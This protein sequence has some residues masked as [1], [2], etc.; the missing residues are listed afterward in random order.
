[1]MLPCL[2]ILVAIAPQ[3][4]VELELVVPRYDRWSIVSPDQRQVLVLE[5]GNAW[6]MDSDS[7][8]PC[9]GVRLGPY[10][11][12]GDH[13]TGGR[14]SRDGERVLLWSFRGAAALLDVESGEEL[15]RDAP[16]DRSS[17]WDGHASEDAR[18]LGQVGAQGVVVH[19]MVTGVPLYE[20][21]IA[22]PACLSPDGRWLFHDTGA[23]VERIDLEEPQRRQRVAEGG[24]DKLFAGA[25]ARLLMVR[26]DRIEV[27]DHE[28]GAGAAVDLPGTLWRLDG[29]SA[30]ESIALVGS[31]N[32]GVRALALPGLELLWERPDSFGVR[33]PAG[34]E[35]VW[36]RDSS[37]ELHVLDLATG[38]S[39]WG[40][41]SKE[42]RDPFGRPPVLAG[43]LL[44]TTHRGELVLRDCRSGEVRKRLT[45]SLRPIEHAGV[46][47]SGPVWASDGG[48]LISLD[49][50][51][52]ATLVRR[53]LGAPVVG[54]H[55]AADRVVAL[56]EGHGGAVL[57]GAQLTPLARIEDAYQAH[58]L[59]DGE[60]LIAFSGEIDGV[61]LLRASDGE[62]LREAGL[63][64]G[65]LRR[66]VASADGEVLAGIDQ[67][68]HGHLWRGDSTLALPGASSDLRSIAL[69]PPGRWLA[70]GINPPEVQ[71]FDA[72]TGA[73]LTAFSPEGWYPFG[74]STR[75]L[76]FDHGGDRLIATIGDMGS[77]QVWRSRDWQLD[78]WHDY[79]GGNPGS[80]AT[81]LDPAGDTLWASGM[82]NHTQRA[83]DLATG[84]LRRNM[85]G[86]G[87]DGFAPGEGVVTALRRG[88]LVLLEPNGALRL[89]RLD[90][91]ELGAVI[92]Q[93]GELRGSPAAL[94][95]VFVLDGG[96]LIR[97]DEYE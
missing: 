75:T 45:R 61:R 50:D 54:A 17:R 73:K 40:L 46:L 78:W 38:K 35:V 94:R 30:D 66:A 82:T 44:L 22:G 86:S 80:L 87:Y 23:A 47:S 31:P 15:A 52:G 55:G 34:G 67:Q 63:G 29:V 24:W 81:A 88:A 27:L 72:V 5:R 51:T 60:R 49:P 42:Y 56:V 57:E 91:G 28:T 20:S 70:L 19:D 84:D 8:Q 65:S 48:T 89:E 85:A 13:W 79:G 37:Y 68:W 3:D 95:Q 96:E 12:Q 26:S 4:K 76:M 14:F 92:C 58:L 97:G 2:L 7:L 93:D 74:G 64:A 11:P 16:G 33:V 62:V 43:A 69:D 1:M 9:L 77:V 36:A 83:F 25:G 59:P 18:L 32:S 41:S 21:T 39:L 10:S 53:D 6:L 90:F 71:I